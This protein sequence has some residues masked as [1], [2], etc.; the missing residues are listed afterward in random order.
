MQAVTPHVSSMRRRCGSG[1]QGRQPGKALCATAFGSSV[2]NLGFR[3][4]EFW[5]VDF[6]ANFW[7]IL[8]GQS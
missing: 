1:A 2:L 7:S 3:A 8:A 6:A 5:V 4:V